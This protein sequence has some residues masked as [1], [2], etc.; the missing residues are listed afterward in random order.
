MRLNYLASPPLVVAYA[1]AGSM[2]IDLTQDALG[3]GS[4]GKSVC[5]RDIWPSR[6][7]IDAAVRAS[8]DAAMFSKT[9]ASVFDGDEN[10]NKLDIP[11]GDRFLWRND[12]T[13]VKK[14]PVLRRHALS[15]RRSR[16]SRA[17]VCSRCSVTR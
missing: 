10:W 1:L 2:E 15:S 9:Y 13:Y 8:V 4:N 12:S 6:H 11:S 5:L 16:T 14:P 3:T 7:E 17:R